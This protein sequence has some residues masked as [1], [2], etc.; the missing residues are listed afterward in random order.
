M[1]LLK[2]LFHLL[3]FILFYLINKKSIIPKIDLI[4][5]KNQRYKRHLNEKNIKLTSSIREK[6]FIPVNVSSAILK[7][8]DIFTGES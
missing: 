3:E 8:E 5:Q 7:Q 2:S 6:W 4:W 1:L